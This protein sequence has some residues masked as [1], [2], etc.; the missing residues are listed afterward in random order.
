MDEFVASLES[1][2]SALPDGKWAAVSVLGVGFLV[3]RKG[4]APLARAL[5]A[6]GP[7]LLACARGTASLA[8][9]RKIDLRSDP[10]TSDELWRLIHRI[11]K[12]PRSLSGPS[13]REFDELRARVAELASEN[14]ARV[15]EAEQ[16]F[17]VQRVVE[18]AQALPEG[19]AEQ[20]RRKLKSK[21]EL[22]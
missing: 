8:S 6:T 1:F 15:L 19:G 12:R 9:G 4:S 3:L 21:R 2:W 18:L 11:E 20:V 16:A 7:G 13:N 14:A 22:A 5:G 10:K 17:R